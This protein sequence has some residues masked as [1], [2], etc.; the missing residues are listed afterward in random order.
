ML[1]SRSRKKSHIIPNFHNVHCV[2]DKLT[3][4]IMGLQHKLD[5]IHGSPSQNNLSMA[6]TYKEMIHSRSVLVDNL[7]KHKDERNSFGIH[8]RIN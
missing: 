7:S 8:R 3:L 2:T 6:Q 5:S 1:R 4:E